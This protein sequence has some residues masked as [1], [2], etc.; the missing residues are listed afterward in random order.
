[1]IRG[2]DRTAVFFRCDRAATVVFL[3][4]RR[5]SRERR[6]REKQGNFVAARA[7]E[8]EEIWIPENRT[9][10]VFP[11]SVNRQT[12]TSALAQAR[13]HRN[14]G[15]NRIDRIRIRQMPPPAPLPRP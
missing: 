2:C 12:E 8:R 3:H 15:A 4:P 10:V 1:M 13:L 7:I 5:A 9:Q 11:I 14:P 6:L